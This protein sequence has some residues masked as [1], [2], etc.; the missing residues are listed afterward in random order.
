MSNNNEFSVSLL[1]RDDDYVKT[2]INVSD[3][4][5]GNRGGWSH[6]KP[7]HVKISNDTLEGALNFESEQYMKLSKN[8]V[9]GAVVHN[10]LSFL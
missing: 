10:D 2:T 6:P 9:L 8:K 3:K 5:F 1:G 4:V 7:C